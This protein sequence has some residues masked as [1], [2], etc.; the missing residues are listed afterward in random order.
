LTILYFFWWLGD[1]VRTLDNVT[2]EPF[3]MGNGNFLIAD[4]IPYNILDKSNDG[5]EV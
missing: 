4:Y 3:W 5:D 2:A 1:N